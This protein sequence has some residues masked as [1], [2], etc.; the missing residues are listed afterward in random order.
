M[1]CETLYTDPNPPFPSRIGSQKSLLKREV[2]Y[3]SDAKNGG[4][5][6]RY[7]C[8]CV[9]VRS[10]GMSRSFVRY[11]DILLLLLLS[12]GDCSRSKNEDA[13]LLLLILLDVFT[14]V[15]E[16]VDIGLCGEGMSPPVPLPSR[17]VFNKKD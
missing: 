9:L 8:C 17:S 3:G 14:F 12:G 4:N 16:V 11:A 15:V 5:E 13:L 6:V 10:A 1:R 7:C 2:V